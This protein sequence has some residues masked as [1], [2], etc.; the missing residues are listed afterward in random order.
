VRE[1]P[2]FRPAR[3]AP[4]RALRIPWLALASAIPLALGACLSGSRDPGGAR[5]GAEALETATREVREA[6]ES[7]AARARDELE[8]ARRQA[9]AIL[10]DRA[11]RASRAAARKARE[12]AQRA[13]RRGADVLAEASRRGSA[14]AEGWAR[15]IQDRMIRLEESLDALGRSDAEHADS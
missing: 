7:A 4:A 2:A 1:V 6:F 8:E 9:E 11:A 12:Q 15:L 14:A 13:L 10:R 5:G 3:P